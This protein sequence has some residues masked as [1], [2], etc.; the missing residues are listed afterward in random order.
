M[1]LINETASLTYDMTY[2]Q[3]SQV[4]TEMAARKIAIKH[5]KHKRNVM[6]QAVKDTRNPFEYIRI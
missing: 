6:I 5:E 3:L 1:N 2:R 4:V